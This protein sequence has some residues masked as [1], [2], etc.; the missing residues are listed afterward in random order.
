M[1]TLSSAA[2]LELVLLV[3]PVGGR[4]QPPLPPCESGTRRLELTAD[5]SARRPEVCIYPGLSTSFF[6]DAKLARV[7][8]AG[9]EWFRVVEGEEGFTLVLMAALPV[10]ERVL[11]TVYFQDGAAPASATF[12]LVVHPSEA[13]RQVEVMRH[14]RTLVSYQQ[15]EQQARAEAQRCREEKARLQAECTGQVGL[16][17]LI[18]QGLMGEG[19]IPDKNIYKS[20]TSSPANTLTNFKSLTY[21]SD[22]AREEGG[23]KVVR[24][25]VELELLNLGKQPWTPAG[26]VL[27][28]PRHVELRVLGVW[29][30]EPIAPGTTGRV[31]VEAEATEETAR[32][33]FTLEL[34]SH[35]GGGGSERFDGVTFP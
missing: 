26:A 8:L 19:G 23:H 24:L 18:T 14:P 20:V 12:E 1:F 10:G 6:F 13:E 21:R 16:T 31:V 33:T 17:G 3:A 7:E 29:P 15:G 4:R 28:G 5:A 32:G 9:R 22:T 2:L 11:V 35:E 30:L 27:V 25:A 34:W